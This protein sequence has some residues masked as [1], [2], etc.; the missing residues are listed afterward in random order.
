MRTSRAGGSFD[1]GVRSGSAGGIGVGAVG[2]L[3]VSI[4]PLLYG[5]GRK[6]LVSGC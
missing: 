1:G 5:Q 2:Q 3:E 6:P 4:L